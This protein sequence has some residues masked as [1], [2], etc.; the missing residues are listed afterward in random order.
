MENKCSIELK[1]QTWFKKIFLVVALDLEM[2]LSRKRDHTQIS[3]DIKDPH[4]NALLKDPFQ[5]KFKQR[6]FCSVLTT[7]IAGR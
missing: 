5:S 4:N 1:E 2:N 3:Q 7:Y 6:T